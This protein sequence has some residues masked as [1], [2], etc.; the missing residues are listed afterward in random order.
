MTSVCANSNVLTWA[1]AVE[2]VGIDE[3]AACPS[4]ASTAANAS[5]ESVNVT[6]AKP[7]IAFVSGSNGT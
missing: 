2:N 3:R 5:R 4:I 1:A 7:R 6:N